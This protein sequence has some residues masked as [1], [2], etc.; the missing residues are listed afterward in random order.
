MMYVSVVVPFTAKNPTEWHPTTPVGP[1]SRLTR[2]A[3]RRE[4]DAHQWAAT[5]IPGHPYELVTYDDGQG[6]DPEDLVE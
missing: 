3:F 2:G 4:A 5:R 1:F 6:L